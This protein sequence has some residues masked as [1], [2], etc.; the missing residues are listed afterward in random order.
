MLY[1]LPIP[2]AHP[3]ALPGVRL[4]PDSRCSVAYYFIRVN[5]T[6]ASI[7]DANGRDW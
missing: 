3:G 6:A 7:G 5:G 2:G 1:H 4:S